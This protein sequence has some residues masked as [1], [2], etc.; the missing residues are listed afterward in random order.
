ME[1]SGAQRVAQVLS[2]VMRVFWSAEEEEEELVAQ[3]ASCSL[4]SPE[5]P[6]QRGVEKPELH[7]ESMEVELGAPLRAREGSETHASKKISLA[8]LAVK[9]LLWLLV[10]PA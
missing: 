7:P 2:S 8:R 5:A 4:W 6:Q 9:L 1:C 3:A 10:S